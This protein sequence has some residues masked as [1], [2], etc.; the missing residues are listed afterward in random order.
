MYKNNLAYVQ[1]AFTCKMHRSA[2]KLIDP[3]F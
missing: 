3:H 2:N 1:D